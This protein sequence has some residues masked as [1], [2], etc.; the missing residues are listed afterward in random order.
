MT[1]FTAHS[2]EIACV[3]ILVHQ[4]C[5]A[6]THVWARYDHTHYSHRPLY[7]GLPVSNLFHGASALSHWPTTILICLVLVRSPYLIAGL[8]ACSWVLWQLAKRMGGKTWPSWWTQLYR[9][10]REVEK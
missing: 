6:L 7:P 3:V 2:V 8:A 5:I 10:F 9:Y 4:F 1:F